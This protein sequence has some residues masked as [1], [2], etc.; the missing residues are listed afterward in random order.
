LCQTP[1]I[2]VSQRRPTIRDLNG[3]LEI[4]APCFFAVALTPW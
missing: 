2:G 1:G 4:A 3:D